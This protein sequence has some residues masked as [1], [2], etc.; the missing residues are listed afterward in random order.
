MYNLPKAI[1]NAIMVHW[2]WGGMGYREMQRLGK[3]INVL[4]GCRRIP[5]L[6]CKKTELLSQF[7]AVWFEMLSKYPE[8]NSFV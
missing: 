6:N 4:Y 8:L 7:K 3:A 1:F 5:R 2:D